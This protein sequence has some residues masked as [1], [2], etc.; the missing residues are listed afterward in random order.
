LLALATIVLLSV[1]VFGVLQLKST[2]NYIAGKVE[3]VFA[4][5]FEG[6]LSIGSLDGI[7]PYEFRMSA[8]RIYPDS[9]SLNPMLT[10]DSLNMG[11][12]P[13]QLLNDKVVF[14]RFDITNPV[15]DLNNEDG[16][17]LASAFQA[18]NEVMDS[19]SDTAG[20]EFAFFIPNIRVRNGEIDLG[21][22]EMKDS[23]FILPEEI[24]LQKLDADMFV[25]MSK[26]QRFLDID[27]LKFE[28][29][30]GNIDD[31]RF[32]GQIFS[33]R[34]FLE[35]NAFRLVAGS[36]YIDFDFEM[37]EVDFLSAPFGELMKRADLRLSVSESYLDLRELDEV[38]SGDIPLE[39]L[40]LNIKVE[41]KLDDLDFE[42][43]SLR[44]NEHLL[45]MNGKL[46]NVNRP[47]EIQYDF[48][49]E[50]AYADGYDLPLSNLSEIQ[51]EAIRELSYSGYFQGDA[52][53]LKI[54]FDLNS[55][56]GH[57]GLDG[58]LALQQEQGYDFDLRID[59]LDLGQLLSP[60]I[61]RSNINGDIHIDSD[62]LNPLAGMGNLD[63]ML[64]DSRV[65]QYQFD[66][67]RIRSD[68]ENGQLKPL[69]FVSSDEA[70]ANLNANINLNND[71][72]AYNVD[73]EVRNLDITDF[74]D[75]NGLEYTKTDFNLDVEAQG[76][77]L[78]D[79]FGKLSLDVTSSI[80]NGDSLDLH[81]LYIDLNAPDEA[82]VLRLTSTPID[83]V[84]SGDINP[85]R[86]R[87]VVLHWM[88]YFVKRYENEIIFA[89]DHGVYE[90]STGIERLELS[91]D[92]RAKDL[93][94]LNSYIPALPEITSN[95]QFIGNI[96][97][98]SRNLLFN[99]SLVDVFN[100]FDEVIIDSLT[101]QITGN[102]RYNSLI[103][104][105]SGLEI[106][107]R[108][109]NVEI[110]DYR[111]QGIQLQSK[112]Q[113]DSLYFYQKVD[114][115]G[116]DARFELLADLRLK[117]NE[118]ALHIRDLLLG[119]NNYQWLNLSQPIIRYNNQEKLIIDEFLAVNDEQLIRLNGVISSDV[120]DSMQYNIQNIDLSDL[121]ELI[122]GRI[123]FA[124]IMNGDFAT[125]SLTQSPSI[126]GRLEIERLSFSENVVGDI[127]I[128]SSFN[129]DLNRFDTQINILTDSTKY[130]E[131]FIRNNRSGQNISI[132]GYI[133]APDL[134]TQTVPDSLYYFDLAFN[135]IDMWIFPFIAPKVFREMEG[136]VTGSGYF[137]GNLEEY[138]FEVAYSADESIY[139]QPRFLE[140]YYYAQGQLVFSSARGL[141]FN[142]FFIIDPS[143]GMATLNGYYDFN[144]FSQNHDIDLRLEMDEFHFL[145][146]SF[147][148]DIPFY[149]DAYGSGIVRMSG[150]SF[151]P[152]IATEGPLIL[153]QGTSLGVPLLEETT[154]EQNRKFIRRVKS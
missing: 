102:F 59:S 99:L 135:D 133:N 18:R 139:I 116:E 142:D 30:G 27:N 22:Q 23:T 126:Q 60:S 25:D 46:R 85:E 12:E 17:S 137:R 77:N 8:I 48:N 147:S 152:V 47:E 101:T 2:K 80:V 44:S 42:R 132:D 120:S 31:F 111:L 105:F 104:D 54:N 125:R 62:K 79:L 20:T 45:V 53:S 64:Q 100:S 93:S 69:F 141:Q 41:G 115:L 51:K 149:G 13:F 153:T 43:L 86:I 130:P 21:K 52:D 145:N 49:L 40:S 112:L 90:D 134:Q 119:N 14:T 76:N 74:A 55:S 107:T 151:N 33:D 78:A 97:A 67:I 117:E 89:A 110:G 146:N 68:L 103:R 84:L 15:I 127:T 138:D 11:I 1:L 66:L 92:L 57:L 34:N 154:V 108:V 32:S 56:R 87:K 37:G 75:I 122:N 91:Y 88:D 19:S 123:D 16:E 136:R 58:I 81:Q 113:N 29:Q 39:N 83:M 36:S 24:K 6:V 109:K 148:I 71:L 144:N 28:L 96:N 124:G 70:F 98:D 118:H 143:G 106:N 61:S 129:R 94:I 95:A 73:G 140:T 50:Q 114:S 131:Y 128:N 121:S 63:I 4:Q 72:Y 5:R 7:I 38:Y 9:T 82:R 35:F 65:N 10:A 3:E 150:T 26:E